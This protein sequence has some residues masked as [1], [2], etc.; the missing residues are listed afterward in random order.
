MENCYASSQNTRCENVFD[1]VTDRITN[2]WSTELYDRNPWIK[3][4]LKAKSHVK[5][6]VIVQPKV[7]IFKKINNITL[8][9]SDQRKMNYTLRNSVSGSFVHGDITLSDTKAINLRISI[10]DEIA[11]KSSYAITEVQLLGCPAI[12]R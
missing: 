7:D 4:D 12:E 2:Y 1:G 9:F 3:I 8:Q 11:D 10:S 5:K 6:I